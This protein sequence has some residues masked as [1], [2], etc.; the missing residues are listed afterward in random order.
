MPAY[1]LVDLNVG[2]TFNQATVQFG[3]SNVM[4][5][6]AQLSR[7]TQIAPQNDTQ[8]YVIPGA[9]AHVHTQGWLQVLI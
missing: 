9:A 5:R 7:F 6:L 2:A 8:V 1:A 4:D 3:V